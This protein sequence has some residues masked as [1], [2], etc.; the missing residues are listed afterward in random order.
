VGGVLFLPPIAKRGGRG[1]LKGKGE[2]L[3]IVGGRPFAM[4]FLNTWGRGHPIDEK[5]KGSVNRE[6]NL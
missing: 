3:Q 6:G 1:P 2:V 4:P 5:G